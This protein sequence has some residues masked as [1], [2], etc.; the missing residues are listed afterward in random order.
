[1]TRPLPYLIIGI[2]IGAI[3]VCVW[4]C[5]D[6]AEI[7]HWKAQYGAEVAAR[8]TDHAASLERIAA[9]ESQQATLQGHI[10]SAE[11]VIVAKDAAIAERDERIAALEAA[12][13]V[14][15]ELESHPLVI[16]LR[17]QIGEWKLKFS[18]AQDVIAEKDRI[19]AGK[20]GI[21]ALVGVPI[22][23]GIKDGKK[24]FRYPE[25]S[26]TWELNNEAEREHALRL[27]CE[28]GLALYAK[29]SRGLRLSST[30]KT[31]A[32]AAVGG[33]VI[34]QAIAK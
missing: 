16:N 8:A 22:L 9:L 30:I 34:Y 28:K 17:A 20:D 32:L 24:V 18:L 7:R 31:V 3:A 27:N 6:S 19:I 33:L 23:V 2:A 4:R 12:E 5:P 13:P 29:Q 1:M 25:G 21:I 15:P 14:A 11:S 10:D 26:V